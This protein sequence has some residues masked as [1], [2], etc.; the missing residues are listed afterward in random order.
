MECRSADAKARWADVD[1]DVDDEELGV[2]EIEF[3]TQK[4]S[5]FKVKVPEA[6][7]EREEE[8]DAVA[9]EG[10]RLGAEGAGREPLPPRLS[11]SCSLA[12]GGSRTAL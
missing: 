7:R 2:E 3:F 12:V 5:G 9:E 1:S 6:P 4:L 8:P 11:P 10:L